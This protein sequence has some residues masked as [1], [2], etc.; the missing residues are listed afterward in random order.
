[1]NRKGYVR[2]ETREKVLAA[3]EELGYVPSS[4]A[5]AL[6]GKPSSSVAL[7]ITD[8]TNP[9]YAALTRGVEDVAQSEG[10]SLVLCNADHGKVKQRQYL[11]RALAA[12]IRGVVIAPTNSALTDLAW[13]IDD[14]VSLVIVDWRYPLPNSDNVYVDSVDG[15]RQ[16]TG[17]LVGLGHTRVG[18]ITGPHGDMT[19]EDR[20]L[21][22]R[23]ALAEAGLDADPE[24]IRFGDFSE[25]F[26]YHACRD[27]LALRPQPTAVVTCNNRLAA[28][29]YRAM[30]ELGL[31]VPE[32]VALVGFD[33]V[34]FVPALASGL[35]VF[36]Q[37]D[38][39]MGRVAAKLLFERMHGKRGPGER[40]EVVL[41]GNLIV[42]ASCGHELVRRSAADCSFSQ[43]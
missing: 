15:G 7:I 31:R 28:G 43:R 30:L 26:G 38:Y 29:A 14:R 16:L 1:M 13:L 37:P 4:S 11:H 10:F 6:K 25:E 2:A 27:L 34:P 41:R 21:G 22:Y 33:D 3:I 12:G 36:A 40:R 18:I 39:E 42:R 35:T 9:F 8:I 5:R 32:D 20:V 24:L 19:A 17:H 23:L